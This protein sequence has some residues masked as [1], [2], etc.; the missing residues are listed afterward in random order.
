VFFKIFNQAQREEIISIMSTQPTIQAILV[1]QYGGVE[2]LKL[3]QVQCPEPS[4]GEVLIRVH[5]AG[6]LPIDWKVRQGMMKDVHTIPFPYIPGS[7]IAGTIEKVGPGVT[8]FQKG[9]SV[10]GRSPKGAYTE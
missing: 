5:A 8:S 2:Q 1:H 10:F 6:I 3:E 4:T 7:S 9:Q